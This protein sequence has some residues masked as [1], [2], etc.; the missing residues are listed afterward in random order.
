[1][2]SKGIK[3]FKDILPADIG[4]WHYLEKVAVEAFER[5]GYSEIR[6]P[7]MEFTEV[8]S[9]SIGEDT[10]IVEKEMY[11]FQEKSGR[12]ITLRPE[13]TA[14]VVRAYIEHGLYAG[15]QPTRFYYLGPMFRYERPQAGRFRQ[16]YQIGVEA[17]GIDEPLLDAEVVMILWHLFEKMKLNDLELQ[18][19]S[20]GCRKCRPIYIKKLKEY[21]GD[22]LPLLCPDCRKRYDLN[23]L[24]ILDCKRDQCRGSIGDAPGILDS[25]C[26]SCIDHFEGV[27]GYLVSLSIPFVINQRIVRGLDY[28]TKTTF[29]VVAKGLGAQNAIAAGGRYDG[30]V[31]DLG[32]PPTPG[33]GFA[34]GVERVISLLGNDFPEMSVSVFLASLG[35]SGHAFSIDIARRIREAGIRAELGYG[36]SLKSQ[37]KKADRAGASYVLIIGDEEMKKGSAILRNMK[38]KSQEDIPIQGVLEVVK[39]KLSDN[40]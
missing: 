36:E 5:A 27:K 1:M 15:P 10:D 38:T 24:R 16:F 19:N 13:G 12:S 20:L 37:M 18:I 23:P 2:E 4:K 40:I 11:T 17:L 26:Q 9:R 22:K 35:S 31:E 7:L 33:I 21:L 32:G 29:E 6:I 28:Y 39:K 30:L 8:F 14:S 34:I 25:L 3:G